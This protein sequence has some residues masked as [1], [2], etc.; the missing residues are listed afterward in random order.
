V[1]VYV[2]LVG[3]NAYQDPV[4]PLS[5]CCDD[6]QAAAEYFAANVRPEEFEPLCLFDEQA[7]RAAVIDGFRT[8]LGRAAAGDTAVFWFSGHGSQAPVPPELAPT[9]PTGMLQTLV[10]VDSRHDGVP[11]LYDKEV[12]LLIGEVAGRGAHVVTI[13]DSCHADGADRLPD[14]ESGGGGTGPDGGLGGLGGLADTGAPGVRSGHSAPGAGSETVAPRRLTARWQPALT[15]PPPLSALLAELRASG[16]GVPAPGGG[17][18]GPRH[19]ALAACRRDQRAQEIPLPG[20][21][22]GVFSLGVLR[23][24]ERLG[25]DATYR[26]LM[27]GVRCYVENLAPHQTP[28]LFPIDDPVVDR[29]FLGGALAVPPTS[30]TMRCLRGVWEI[31]AGA[32]HGITEGPADDRPRV[33]VHGSGTGGTPVREAEIV[34]VRAT[35]SVVRPLAGWKPD[36]AAQ[37]RVVV[38]SVPVP[39]AVVEVAALPQGADT[40]ELLTK[41]LDGPGPDRSRLV[42]PTTSGEAVP[43]LVVAVPRSGVARIHGAD[44]VPLAPEVSVADQREAARLVADLEHIARWRCIKALENPASRLAGE[45]RIELVAADSAAVAPRVLRTGDTGCVELEYIRY[46][47]DWVPPEVLVTLRNTGNRQLFCVLLDLTDRFRS[48]IGLFPGDL[49]G[50]HWTAWAANGAPIT[51]ALPAD[52]RPEPGAETRDWLKVLIAE[53]PFNASPFALPRLGES[54]ATPDP[55]PGSRG[56]A[57]LHGVLGRMGRAVAGRDAP[58]PEPAALDWATAILPVVTR[59]PNG[60][61]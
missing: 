19:V 29:A 51:F 44:G 57:A 9:E 28:I 55:G 61:R 53:E 59:V 31:D 20:G 12:A 6:I 23:Q 27:T 54:A 56:A 26:D 5:G 49:V 24:L 33:G 4:R 41:A 7:T 45:I 60:A 17:S 36:A 42:R 32:C 1:S 58:P 13:I 16:P 10:C 22:R 30:V 15:T 47:S 40:A 8:H 37:Y 39:A 35:T 18:A 46:G 11:D 25:P 50:P 2:L 3:I 52:R 34:Q 48:E 38:T 43:D 14:R 21:W